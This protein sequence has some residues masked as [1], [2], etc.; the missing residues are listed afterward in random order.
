MLVSKENILSLIPQRPPFV[1]ID[2]LTACD[3]VSSIT[4]FRIPQQHVLVEDGVF[5]EAG[6]VENIAQT[7][8][9]GV[10][11][12]VQQN[13]GDVATGYI[14]AIK[15]LDVLALPLVGDVLKTSVIIINKVFDVTVI[16]GVVSSNGNLLAKCEMKI[17]TKQ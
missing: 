14:A 8:A 9:A 12:M 15:N 3:E 13:A 10:G 17:F 1:V 4:T 11:Y 16:S 6:L 7:A 2:G 5:S